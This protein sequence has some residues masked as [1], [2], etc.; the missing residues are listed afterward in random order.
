[1]TV[2]IPNCCALS[3]RNTSLELPRANRPAI[4]TKN[5][6]LQS[7]CLRVSFGL[8][9]LRGLIHRMAMTVSLLLFRDE[10][11][12]QQH[13]NDSGYHREPE[14]LAIIV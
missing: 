13:G 11:Y 1:M 3:I 14:D 6:N 10:K 2:E 4:M 5:L 9:E 7:K 8:S 12:Y